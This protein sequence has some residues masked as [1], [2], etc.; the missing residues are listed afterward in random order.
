MDN[1]IRINNSREVEQEFDVHIQ[2]LQGVENEKGAQIR[3]VITNV[4]G[5]DLSL[6]CERRTDSDTKWF[7]KIPALPMLKAAT[8]FRIELIV[9]GYYFEPATGTVIPFKDPEI[10]VSNSAKPKVSISILSSEKDKKEDDKDESKEGESTEPKPEKKVSETTGGGGYQVDQ[11]PAATNALLKPEFPPDNDAEGDERE[12]MGH[13]RMPEDEETDEDKLTPGH[14]TDVDDDDERGKKVEEAA[15][16]TMIQGTLGKHKKPE[17]PG[18]LFQRSESGKAVIEGL[19]PD[20]QT[21]SQL[22]RKQAAA[23]KVLSETPAS[24]KTRVR[25]LSP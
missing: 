6:R 1:Q 11:Q 17:K 24:S 21:K 5:G 25:K 10:K 7:V 18:F 2:G 16:I 9:D 13:R 15:T 8:P 14:Y 4:S 19:E 12:R 3:F 22:A 20:A 23:K